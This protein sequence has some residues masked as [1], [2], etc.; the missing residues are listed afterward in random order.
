MKKPV[1]MLVALGLAVAFT[2]PAFA[3]APGAQPLTRID[4]QKAGL[5]WNDQSNVCG[6]QPPKRIASSH[7][8]HS[9]R[10]ASHASSSH[11]RL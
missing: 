4:C 3:A 10:T 9:R 8:R 2:A 7:E 6:Q 5:K 11:G 1:S